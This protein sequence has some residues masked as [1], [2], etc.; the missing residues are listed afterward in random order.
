MN[1]KIISIIVLNWNGKVYLKECLESLAAQTYKNFEVIF[2]DN[3]SI[4]GSIEYVKNNFPEVKILTLIKNTGFCKG[5]NEG[6]KISN[7]EYVALLNND[8]KTDPYWLE[9]LHKAILKYP[10]VGFYASKIIFY[11]DREKIDAVGDGYSFCGAGFK[12]GHFEHKDKYNKEEKVFG[13][14]AGA[15]IYKKSMLNDIGLLDEDFF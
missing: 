10:S 5:N 2:V 6:I 12:R 8:T 3:G 1:Q 14:C 13:S 9:E 7:G 4:D 15:A 11:S